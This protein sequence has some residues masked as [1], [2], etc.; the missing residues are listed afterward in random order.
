MTL[1]NFRTI[2]LVWD[3]A[4]KSI[5]K[6]IK[7]ASS[8]TTG[9]YLSVK[10]L[11]E[12]QE[13]TLNNAKLQLYWE[14]PNFNTSGT[15]DFN[16][17]NNGGL[18]KMTFSDE[19]L[20]NIG[21][22]NA[23]LVLTLTDGK[24]T[25]DG[26]PIEVFKG[27]DDGV[28]VPTNGSG[29]V[30]QIDGKIDKGNVTLN[31]LTQE[32]KL[33]LTG[34]AVAV[35]GDGA[36]DTENIKDDAVTIQ[37]AEFIH[38]SR[39]LFDKNKAE[40]GKWWARV[41]G[42]VVLQ[43]NPLL[44]AHPAI[45]VSQGEVYYKNGTGHIIITDENNYTIYARGASDGAGAHTVPANGAYMYVNVY[46]EELDTYQLEKGSVGTSYEPF[47]ITLD[48]GIKIE[49][50]SV[51]LPEIDLT[52]KQ[53]RL[54]AGENIVINKDNVISAIG[55]ATNSKMAKVNSA[56]DVTVYMPIEKNEYASY[57]FSR[58]SNEDY[59][60]MNQNGIYTLEEGVSLINFDS[61]EGSTLIAPTSANPYVTVVGTKVIT[62]FFG[63]GIKIITYADNR[64]GAWKI[65]IDGEDYGTYSTWSDVVVQEKPLFE[66]LNLPTSDHTIILEYI[67]ADPNNVVTSPRG[68][69]KRTDQGAWEAYGNVEAKKLT[70]KFELT[71][72]SSNKEFAF[73][74]SPVDQSVGEWFPQHNSI[75]TTTVGT[76]GIQTLELDGQ[77]IDLNTP[78]ELIEFDKGT[79]SQVA[80]SKLSSETDDRA[81]IV[82]SYNFEKTVKQ[83]FEME[84]L[85]DTVINKG[86][87]FMLPARGDFADKFKSNARETKQAETVTA[88][89]DIPFTNININE[90][91]ATSD[92]ID[93]SSYFVRTKWEN[94]YSDIV[95]SF[96]QSRAI[97]LQK[98][99]PLFLERETVSAGT[100]VYFDGEWEIGKIKNANEIYG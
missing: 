21:E 28:V 12:G 92:N 1:D 56:G 95:S 7:T 39:N 88:D 71:D 36:V 85:K 2:E 57:R 50:D 43:D 74:V 24:I 89:I 11:D 35:V 34:G 55:N 31:D 58:N 66:K 19:M 65:S 54:I 86:Y 26:F 91:I 42:Y 83:Y 13:V 73:N 82:I 49:S 97:G 76:K 45:P 64:G 70:P 4:N 38:K 10:I 98:V 22:L 90:I 40:K 17:I 14:H 78:S 46:T 69:L 29:L 84:F 62:N 51:D 80:Y 6:T 96:L 30:K 68:W 63:S 60:K 23:H 25:S 3:K 44:N 75:A 87:A 67:G 94:T 59:M 16:T 53:D 93:K 9:R 33:A 15:D 100:I 72:S 61:V 8:D 99:Y 81:K 32:V 37:K 18:F 52:G 41:D 20:T 77:V 48:K 27:A 79:F 47:G 5:I